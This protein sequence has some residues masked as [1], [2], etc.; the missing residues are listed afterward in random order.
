MVDDQVTH[1]NESLSGVTLPEDVSRHHARHPTG[2]PIPRLTETNQRAKHNR[3][4]Q[5]DWKSIA[6]WLDLNLEEQ[7][8]K[9]KVKMYGRTLHVKKA[10]GLM[11]K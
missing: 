6:D 5:Q 4:G 11:M 9:K 7:K 2:V 1:L 3:S 10:F 8:E